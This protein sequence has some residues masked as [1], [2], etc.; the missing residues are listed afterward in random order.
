MK[1]QY[2]QY[3]SPQY[4]TWI[5]EAAAFYGRIKTF[6]TPLQT[7]RITQHQK[8]QENVYLTGFEKGAKV[9]VNYSLQDVAYKGK[10]IPK[11]D[12]LITDGA[13]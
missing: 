4:K 2:Q 3:Y 11:Q 9:I 5:E 7:Q 13:V 6:M 1:T 12:F 10:T 8:L